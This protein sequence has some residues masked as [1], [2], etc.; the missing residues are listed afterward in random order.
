ME[1]ENLINLV[2]R[3]Q[4]GDRGAIEA[5]LC[6]A[7]TWVSYQCR[8]MFSNPQ[9]AED[10][11]QEVLLTIYTKLHTLQQP[12]A[13][14]KWVNRITAARCINKLRSTH[15]EYQFAKDEDGHSVVVQLEDLDEQVIPD[16]AIDNAE[17]ARMISEVVD[18]L[19]DVQRAA[20]LMF[21]YNEMSVKEIAC[22]MGVSENTVKSRLNYARK[23]IKEK[24]LDY[25]KQGV[26]LYG[27]SPLPFL[28]YFLRVAAQGSADPEAAGII[29]T[30]VMSSNAV[31]TG[32]A[33]SGTAVT[34]TTIGAAASAGV[35]TTAHVSGGIFLKVIAAI[36]A[37]VVAIGGVAAGAAAIMGGD[38]LQP[39]TQLFA[40]AP[41]QE[42]ENNDAT[43]EPDDAGTEEATA[44][45]ETEVHT[46]PAETEAV[47]DP[48]TEPVTEESTNA[49]EP[50]EEEGPAETVPPTTEAPE[51][52]PEIPPAVTEHTCD[53]VITEIVDRTCTS[54]GYV[55][56]RCTIC[57]KT[58]EQIL[59]WVGHIYENGFCTVCGASSATCEHTY[60]GGVE[61]WPAGPNNWDP[62]ILYTCTRCGHT[63]QELIDLPY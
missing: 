32:V 14:Q 34:P 10:M 38:L 26:K 8:K 27:L 1:K 44:P 17:T 46:E 19:P 50:V 16:K 12:A 33:G 15:I 41:A 23:A 2:K 31:V 4:A 6:H 48:A 62:Y 11:T 57:G 45:E 35:H 36:V 3:S 54:A 55:T 20:T 5:L 60:D 58:G 21:Y 7:H 24:V 42:S 22:T 52:T 51:P 30:E 9:D 28:L 61:N 37:G 25:E 40:M 18:S 56:Y 47:T 59:G 39:I 13:F 29:V 63:Y 49:T 53:N 43:S